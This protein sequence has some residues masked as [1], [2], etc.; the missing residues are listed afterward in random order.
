MGTEIKPR[1]EPKDVAD[2]DDVEMSEA[3]VGTFPVF[4]EHGYYPGLDA[5]TQKINFL[6]S[7]L[8]KE[9]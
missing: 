9:G 1:L 8:S 5:R 6:Q 7:D 2:L 3:P 4:N